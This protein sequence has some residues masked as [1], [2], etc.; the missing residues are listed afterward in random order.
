[1]LYA[2]LLHLVAGFVTGSVFKAR[3]LLLV[4]VCAAAEMTAAAG[5]HGSVFTLGMIGNLVIIQIGYA[6]GLLTRLTV[7]RSLAGAAS[8]RTHRAP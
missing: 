7:E 2:L 1:M 5:L 3:T 6:G 8:P 4:L